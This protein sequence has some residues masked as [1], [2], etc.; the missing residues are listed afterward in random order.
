V[1]KRHGGRRRTL[2]ARLRIDVEPSLP[3]LER[4]LDGIVR[5]RRIDRGPAKAIL[6][7][8]QGVAALL[9]DAGVALS[10]RAS[11]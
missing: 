3:D 4:R 11:A 5:P 1:E 10:G 2:L 7:H 6:N 8:L 9:V